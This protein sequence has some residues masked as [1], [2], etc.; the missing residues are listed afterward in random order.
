MATAY[1]APTMN[2]PVVNT[3]SKV[4][5]KPEYTNLVQLLQSSIQKRGER[6]LF[7]VMKDGGL[8]WTTYRQF[9][10]MVDD[11]RAGL[12]QL[13]V[14]PGD[15]VAVISNNRLEWA[16]GAH[17]TYSLGATYVPMYEA[18][19]DEQWQ[20]VLADSGAKVCL[21]ASAA[22]EN[23]VR[24]LKDL[25]SALQYI[26]NFEGDPADRLSYAAL[27]RSGAEHPVALTMPHDTDIAS[28]IY[29]S[30]T[31]GNPKGVR[32]SHFNLA[33]NVSALL[34]LVDIADQDRSV[35]FLPWAHVFGGCVE[36][37]SAIATGCSMAICSDPMQLMEY[38]TAVKPTA[39][40]AVPRVW[41]K[42]YDSVKKKMATKP[43]A[44]QWIF[45]TG[46]EARGKQR[47]GERLELRESLGLKM[48][49]KVVFPKVLE[50]LGGE[51]RFACSGAA[52]LAPE[53]AEF[54]VNLGIEVYEGYGMTETGGCTTASSR[55]NVRLGAVGKPI[56]GVRIRID[57]NV[58]SSGP[59]EGE[60]IVYGTGVM[61]GYH[62]L[63]EAT[64][65]IMTEDGGLRT[66]DLGRLDSEGFLYIT[67]RVKEL[68][69]LENGKYIAPVPL[70]EKIQMSPYIMQCMIHGANKPYNVAI[71]VPDMLALREWAK[72]AGIEADD[73]SLVHDARVR[74]LLEGEVDAH[75]KSF[76]GFERIKAFFICLEPFSIEN[77]M[78]THSLKLKRRNVVAKYGY[79]FDA[80]YGLEETAGE[81]P[82]CSYIREL[83]P[84][85]KDKSFARAG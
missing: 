70:E 34:T 36:Q 82:R 76:K 28:F 11:F 57:Q 55:G 40:F 12:A 31:T 54:L 5:F 49:E 35:A 43:S 23:R 60:I 37:N 81:A 44:I 41:H 15:R 1:V 10:R 52:A 17:A 50:A 38:I 24:R 39:L 73:E 48:A 16:V 62:K 30:G 20:Y 45:N 58:E 7:G 56:P 75:S 33:S 53:V 65:D 83:R 14:G 3:E 25:L 59:G 74:T 66:G 29:T 9:G 69:K 51:L 85:S 77:D 64:R 61:A 47:R 32:L 42:V 13:G 2:R 71:V 80:L 46:I 26:V 67:G 21:V 72:N 84:N 27:M 79:L 78:L 8:E 18:Q 63:D 4:D 68:Y 19:R 22:I 6:E